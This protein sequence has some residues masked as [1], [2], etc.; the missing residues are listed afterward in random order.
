MGRPL[1]G[2]LFSMDKKYHVQTISTNA[3]EERKE[4]HLIFSSLDSDV[5]PSFSK[6]RKFKKT[7]LFGDS[8]TFSRRYSQNSQHNESDTVET[9]RLSIE[10]QDTQK[11]YSFAKEFTPTKFKNPQQTYFKPNKQKHIQIRDMFNGL[12]KEELLASKLDKFNEKS[13]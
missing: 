3:K 10:N 9:R 4:K 12:N 5:P 1:H 11:N 13:K 6:R 7:S 2:M 8:K